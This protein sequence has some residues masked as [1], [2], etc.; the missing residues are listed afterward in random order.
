MHNTDAINKVWSQYVPSRRSSV[1]SKSTFSTQIPRASKSGEIFQNINTTCL[2]HDYTHAIQLGRRWTW[3]D[4]IGSRKSNLDEVCRGMNIC[5]VLVGCD[6]INPFLPSI[7]RAG[8]WCIDWESWSAAA[9]LERCWV[10]VSEQSCRWVVVGGNVWR[11]WT[12]LAVFVMIVHVY[13]VSSAL[14]CCVVVWFAFG[15]HAHTAF[16]CCKTRF[17]HTTTSWK[18]RLTTTYK[19]HHYFIY[20]VCLT[21]TSR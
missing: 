13:D 10:G 1:S 12:F 4:S 5:H 11:V 21:C 9:A 17:Q 20:D 8:D 14:C 3:G 16:V 6:D 15:V 19:L 18:L 7:V 2:F